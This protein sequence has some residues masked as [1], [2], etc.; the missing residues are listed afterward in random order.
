MILLNYHEFDKI[1]KGKMPMPNDKFITV[2]G[3]ECFSGKEFDISY[4]DDDRYIGLE[5]CKDTDIAR[6]IYKDGRRVN[7]NASYKFN[8]YNNVHVMHSTSPTFLKLFAEYMK[9]DPKTFTINFAITPPISNEEID[10]VD[11]VDHIIFRFNDSKYI[12]AYR[13]GKLF[14]V[15]RYMH[16]VVFNIINIL[17]NG[18]AYKLQRKDD[19]I[20]KLMLKSITNVEYG[21][22][23]YEYNAQS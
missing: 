9:Y 21:A 15:Y 10:F 12:T 18:F 23:E 22:Y 5:I 7:F 19:A 1:Y 14:F 17:A 2:L 13:L 6:A 20:F 11:G 3:Y 4:L 16:I 8:G